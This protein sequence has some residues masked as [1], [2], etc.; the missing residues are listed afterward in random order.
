[1]FS[2]FLSFAITASV[3]IYL[4]FKYFR[5]EIN[6]T[7]KEKSNAEILKIYSFYSW[8]LYIFLIHFLAYIIVYL[9]KKDF[10]IY[11]IYGNFLS[12]LFVL[13]S[14]FIDAYI[15]EIEVNFREINYELTRFFFR[16]IKYI[17]FLSIF[18]IAYSFYKKSPDIDF[19][20]VF[21]GIVFSVFSFGAISFFTSIEK[22]INISSFLL[23]IVS[24][25]F[26][27][28]RYLNQY[29]LDFLSVIF[30]IYPISEIFGIIFYEKFIRL[31]NFKNKDTSIIFFV[32]FI[33]P[34]F[35]KFYRNLYPFLSVLICASYFYL[36]LNIK[37]I[38][39][40]YIF[41]LTFIGY[42]VFKV[43]SLFLSK[44]SIDF[45]GDELL[46]FILAL[47]SPFFFKMALEMNFSSVFENED[48]YVENIGFKIPYSFITI[49]LILFF[50]RIY[51][52]MNTYYGYSDR[53]DLMVSV[54]SIFI[55]IVYEYFYNRFILKTEVLI[56]KIIHMLSIN[57]FI[58]SLIIVLVSLFSTVNF[59]N[60]FYIFAIMSLISVFLSK[61]FITHIVPIFFLSGFYLLLYV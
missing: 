54:F 29:A 7:L 51:E 18:I 12:F 4:F 48:N 34:V 47:L 9:I 17:L 3:V 38:R 2:L 46:F 27:F 41:F 40:E 10:L 25:F 32:I 57:I 33:I 11:F 14:I 5:T 28:L 22:N 13:V 30:L 52:L 60:L 49:V 1:M 26:I 61:N 19:A 44:Y 20:I 35:L 37:N 50:N 36:L 23:L 53:G 6:L 45:R 24:S 31:K 42:F 55:F 16:M 59:T 39:K 8:F 56:L 21:G 58:F 43:T 15:F